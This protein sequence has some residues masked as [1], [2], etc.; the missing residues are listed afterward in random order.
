MDVKSRQWDSTGMQRALADPSNRRPL[1][2]AIGPSAF[3]IDEMEHIDQYQ[4]AD[5]RARLTQIDQSGIL[6]RE[7]EDGH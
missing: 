2:L 7:D 4:A 5:L 3:E 6:D 1:L